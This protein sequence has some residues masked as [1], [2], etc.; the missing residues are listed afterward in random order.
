MLLVTAS[1]VSTLAGT[2]AQLAAARSDQPAAALLPSQHQQQSRPQAS[3]DSAKQVSGGQQQF[4]ALRQAMWQ[5]LLARVGRTKAPEST[6]QVEPGR[7]DAALG[8]SQVQAGTVPETSGGRL[9]HGNGLPSPVE[10][11]GNG[12]NHSRQ[13]DEWGRPIVQIPMAS[14]SGVH[15]HRVSDVGQSADK[16]PSKILWVRQNPEEHE[17]SN[18]TG[19]SNHQTDPQTVL[20]QREE[21]HDHAAEQTDGA[22]RRFRR[23]RLGKHAV[24]IESLLDNVE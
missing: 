20:W 8:S 1:I 10:S 3:G 2:L 17:S 4:A 23:S 13:Q 16:L 11:V 22:P 24:S 21:A 15:Q 19:L 14:A 9:D 12:Q 7:A 6:R 18:G 5:G